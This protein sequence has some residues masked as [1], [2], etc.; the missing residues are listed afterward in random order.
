MNISNILTSIQNG[1]WAIVL[2]GLTLIQIAPIQINPWSFVAK[3]IGRAI[4][5]EIITKVDRLS[6]DITSLRAECDEREADSCRTRILRFN[7]ELSHD[8]THS[9]E[10]F[11]QTLLD[12]TKYETYCN[13]HPGYKNN[14]A[15]LA[16]DRIKQTY[17]KCEKDSTFL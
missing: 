2:A 17:I 1:W 4:N 11:D 5:G 8:V 7:D 15:A 3:K 14:I 10:H 12:I 6:D 16:I 9:K 13:S